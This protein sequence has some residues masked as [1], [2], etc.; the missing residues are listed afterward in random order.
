MLSLKI[1]ATF[2]GGNEDVRKSSKY[3]RTSHPN[4][5]YSCAKTD[6]RSLNQGGD[7][8]QPNECATHWY[9]SPSH[10]KMNQSLTPVAFFFSF[11]WKCRYPFWMSKGMKS[12]PFLM[13]LANSCRDSIRKLLFSECFDCKLNFTTNRSFR[14]S[15][16]SCQAVKA[17]EIKDPYILFCLA[18]ACMW[19][20]AV[21]SFLTSLYLI[22]A[23]KF[24][25][26]LVSSDI[27]EHHSFPSPN[28]G[29]RLFEYSIY[30]CSAHILWTT[31]S[32]LV[33]HTKLPLV[34]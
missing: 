11:S 3:A 30:D 7:R 1:D 15:R 27:Q 6:K 34:P 5:S 8:S 22:Y 9:R 29:S 25:T 21:D 10:L 14:P 17:D 33:L 23:C 28:E 19:Y 4:L 2:P 32:V 24:S 13:L 12:S 18:C 16:I 31:E 26:F 20:L